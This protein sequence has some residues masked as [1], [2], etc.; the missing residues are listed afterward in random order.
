MPR[1]A[2]PSRCLALIS[3][4][5]VAAFAAQP[6]P[7]F[8][9]LFNEKDLAGW[10]GG[11]TYDHRQLLE[12][13]AAEREALIAKWTASLTE[14]KD[15]KPHWRVEGGVLVNDGFGG[16]ATTRQDY[17]DFELMLDFKL[18]PGADSGVYLRGVPQVQIWDPTMP[19]PKG[20]GYAKGS[21]GLWN[22]PKDT[23]G[24]DPLVRADKPV[25]EW[26]AL[27]VLMVGSRVSVWLNQKLVVDH[28][29]L[30]NYYDKNNKKL[31]PEERRPVPAR[32]PIQLQTHG[33]AT[34][35]RNIYLREIGSDEAN[36][37]LASRGAEGFKSI[38]N[39]KTL[40]GWMIEEKGPVKTPGDVM[41]IKDGTLVWRAGRGGTPYWKEELSDFQAR[42]WF[43]IPPGGNNGLAIRY[44][45]KG[46][47]AY[48]GMTELQII[49]ENYYAARK[50]P[51]KKLDPRQYHGSVY[52]MVPAARGYLRPTADWNFQEVTVKGSTLRVEL[53]GT[54]ILD[55]D[56]SKV[57]MATV[58]SKSPHPGKDRKS[59]FFGLAG[60]SDP[61]EFKELSI[62]KL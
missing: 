1:F 52:G 30:E 32:G 48:D 2:L 51:D 11:T 31:K 45:G 39:G 41:E 14:L 40:D 10:R 6:P 44:P 47:T 33:G 4:F 21:G 36:R 8:T 24:R 18:A 12:Q 42:V 49:D 29:V 34:H 57:D 37:L 28:V 46:N 15:G 59:G 22:N 7:G 20:H 23:P 55:T 35:W 56:L 53:N 16:Y 54:V 43:K 38:F 17:G 27:R 25:G 62:K 5:A 58:M 60:H 61:V 13:P 26:N 9:R 50:Q 3:T 19:D